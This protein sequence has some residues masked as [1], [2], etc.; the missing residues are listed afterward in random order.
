[1]KVKKSDTQ[2]VK[3]S[4][5]RKIKVILERLHLVAHFIPYSVTIILLVDNYASTMILISIFLSCL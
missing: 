1:M 2:K 5:A 3:K 4:D